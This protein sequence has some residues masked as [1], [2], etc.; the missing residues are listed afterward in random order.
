[1]LFLKQQNIFGEVHQDILS[2]AEEET[3]HGNIPF[4]TARGK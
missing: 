3:D 4:T 1:M 2:S